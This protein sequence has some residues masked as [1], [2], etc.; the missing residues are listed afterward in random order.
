MTPD[1]ILAHHAQLRKALQGQTTGLHAVSCAAIET[2][3]AREAEV[4]KD[5]KNRHT[6]SRDDN[7]NVA[8]W[9]A[10]DAARAIL[11]PQPAALA[12]EKKNG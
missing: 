10:L 6:L 2:L 11:N 3:L 9:N 7:V 12:E 4:L 8:L 1:E 5:L